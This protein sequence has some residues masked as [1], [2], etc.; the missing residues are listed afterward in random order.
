MLKAGDK[1]KL[2]DGIPLG[3][4]IPHPTDDDLLVVVYELCSMIINKKGIPLLG[5]YRGKKWVLEDAILERFLEEP[6]SIRDL[7]IDMTKKGKAP[8]LV[9]EH[10]GY[11]I[12]ERN[13]LYK[14]L[15]DL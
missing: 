13:H 12:D 9:L 11:N 1:V 14:V 10:M 2:A 15:R 5:L 6:V 8:A 3:I 4:C 7:I